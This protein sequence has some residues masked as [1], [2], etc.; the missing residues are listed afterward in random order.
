MSLLRT[1]RIIRFRLPFLLPLIPAFVV[2]FT[3]FFYVTLWLLP[4]RVTWRWAALAALALAGVVALGVLRTLLRMPSEMPDGE[5]LEGAPVADGPAVHDL[6]GD[7]TLEEGWLF[8]TTHALVFTNGD[9]SIS[10]P[11]TSLTEVS[12]IRYRLGRKFRVCMV[13][14]R[15]RDFFVEPFRDWVTPVQKARETHAIPH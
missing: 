7:G 4:I 8:L 9:Q 12:R 10:W 3:P 5:A 11:L 1:I 13:G 15:P 2:V 14:E 6:T